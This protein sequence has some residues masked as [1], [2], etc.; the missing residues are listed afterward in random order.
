MMLEQLD[1]N[2]K[3]NEYIFLL[4]FVTVFFFIKSSF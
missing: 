3:Y 4:F 2:K 1:P